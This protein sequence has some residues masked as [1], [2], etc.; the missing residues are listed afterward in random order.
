MYVAVLR[1]RLHIPAARSLKDRRMVVRRL[2]ERARARAAVT[3]ADV[4]PQDRWQLASLGVC[5]VSNDASVAQEQVD[6]ALAV[7]ESAAVGDALVTSRER[8]LHHYDER[9]YFGDVVTSQ[10]TPRE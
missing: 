5:A 7:I 6:R 2:V 9:E 1:V 3:I 8:D 10:S 4:G